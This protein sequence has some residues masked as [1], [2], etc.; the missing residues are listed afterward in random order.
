VNNVGAER[1]FWYDA[2]SDDEEEIHFVA[3]EFA[4]DF[5]RNRRIVLERGNVL[6]PPADDEVSVPKL[7]TAFALPDA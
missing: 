3:L 5:P 2:D 7:P 6:V 4:D 1:M